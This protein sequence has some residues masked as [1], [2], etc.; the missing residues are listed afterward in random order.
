MPEQTTMEDRPAEFIWGN[1]ERFDAIGTALDIL[2]HAQR[3]VGLGFKLIHDPKICLRC[4]ATIALLELTSIVHHLERE[5][6]E[7]NNGT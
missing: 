4:R 6:E 2:P 7:Q 1:K 5:S 3:P